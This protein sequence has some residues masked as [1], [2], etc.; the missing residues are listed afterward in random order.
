MTD[1]QK[2]LINEF[3]KNSQ[4]N[5][6]SIKEFNLVLDKLNEFLMPFFEQVV[7]DNNNL[8]FFK[9]KVIGDYKIGSNYGY[10]DFCYIMFDVFYANENDLE[11]NNSR[12][13]KGEMGK[14]LSDSFNYNNNVLPTTTNLQNAL[15]K[16]LVLKGSNFKVFMRKNCIYLKFLDYKFCLFF[17]ANKLNSTEVNFNLKGKTYHFNLD[18]MNKNLL[19]KNEK[20]NGHLFDLIKFFK[21]IEK[22][23]TLINKLEICAGKNLY[24]YENLLFNIPNELLNN[25]NIYDD[26]M[27]SYNYI[28]SSC[29][30]KKLDEFVDG[31]NLKLIDDN[32]KLFA[33]H[34]I[35]TQDVKLVLKNCRN[36]INNQNLIFS[37]N[38][39]NNNA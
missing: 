11:Y 26:F 21:I 37:D 5:N 31:A 4:S 15:F 3:V 16:Y 22:E 35:T 13:Q 30:Q 7:K 17:N 38:N 34:Y 14:L 24:F 18:L 6:S 39:Q 2:V 8:I 28:L 27:L 32:Y 20:T 10:F 19:E 29:K 23:L 1:D 36:F 9:N 25:N 12:Q 33:K